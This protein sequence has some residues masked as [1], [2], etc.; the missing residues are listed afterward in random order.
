MKKRLTNSNFISGVDKLSKSILKSLTPDENGKVNPFIQIPEEFNPTFPV[1]MSSID[2]I[3]NGVDIYGLYM[4][5]MS[6]EAKLFEQERGY[7][8]GAIK[9]EETTKNEMIDLLEKDTI[10]INVVLCC[11]LYKEIMDAVFYVAYE[12]ANCIAT[13]LEM[14]REIRD[15][16]FRDLTDFENN[17]GF[18]RYV[19]RTIADNINTAKDAFC[20]D[21]AIFNYVIFMKDILGSQISDM[22]YNSCRNLIYYSH[23]ADAHELYTISETLCTTYLYVIREVLTVILMNFQPKISFCYSN[24]RD[25]L[26]SIHDG[27]IYE[28]DEEKEE[29]EK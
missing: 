17:Y 24:S 21:Y 5:E 19:R 10:R 22:W 14:P 20:N 18:D 27:S 29:S 2:T 7:L 1:V 26:R 25:L 9:D 11:E 12:F 6:N 28:Q 15:G 13:E 4:N 3:V 16:F 8:I 23:P